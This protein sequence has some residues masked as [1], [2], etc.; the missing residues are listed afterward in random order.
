[1]TRGRF[2]KL[3]WTEYAKAFAAS[4]CFAAVVYGCYLWS[5]PSGV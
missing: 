4:C 3:P 1:M 5:M 2:P